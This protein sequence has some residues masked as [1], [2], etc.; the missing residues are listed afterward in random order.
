MLSFLL[1]VFALVVLLGEALAPAFV[2]SLLAPG[3][4]APT[5]QLT[6][7]LTRIMLAQPLILAVATVV[8]ALLNSRNQFFLTAISVVSHN[9]ALILGILATRAYPGLGIYGPTFGVVLGAVLL[10]RRAITLRTAGLAAIL[11]L[12][13]RPE[14]LL[15]PGF[16][17]SF[18]AT[19]ALVSGFAAVDRE[20]LL[21]RWPRWAV[22]VFTLVASSVIA[23][24]ATAPYAA[25]TFNRFTDYGL[26]ANLL[27]VPVMGAL[28]S[29]PG[30]RS[31]S[32]P[33]C[34]ATPIAL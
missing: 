14:S 17:M 18:A 8:T 4:D 32:M 33:S 2:G 11:L 34:P 23:G 3:F 12:L 10:D 26:L 31:Q 7:T 13:A 29:V 15:E 9:V 21:E 24:F 20:V 27:T 16:Q 22:P 30:G 6:V 1:A 25:A 19:V 28:T 5:Q